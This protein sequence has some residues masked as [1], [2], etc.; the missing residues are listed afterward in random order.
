MSLEVPPQIEDTPSNMD[1]F[2]SY[3]DFSFDPASASVLLDG[4]PPY[5]ED[6]ATASLVGYSLNLSQE[7]ELRYPDPP[8]FPYQ[9]DAGLDGC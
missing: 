7:A 4:L 6:G 5:Q 9:D 3:F 8:D 2:S 1:I